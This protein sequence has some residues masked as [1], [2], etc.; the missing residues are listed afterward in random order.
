LQFEQIFQPLVEA[1]RAESQAILEAFACG[2]ASA[3]TQ[4]QATPLQQG[5]MA[6]QPSSLRTRFERYV[7]RG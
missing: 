1:G 2:R 5:L 4:Q 3:I 7:S 6:P